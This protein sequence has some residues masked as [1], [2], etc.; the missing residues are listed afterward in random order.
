[1]DIETWR[2]REPDTLTMEGLCADVLRLMEAKNR[3]GPEEKR[4]PLMIR[5]EDKEQ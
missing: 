5:I 4:I 2:D 3:Q 1:M